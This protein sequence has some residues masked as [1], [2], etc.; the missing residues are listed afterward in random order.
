[1]IY[2]FLIL[3]F[4]SFQMCHAAAEENLVTKTPIEI[5]KQN[6][7]K[8]NIDAYNNS[9]IEYKKGKGFFV[10]INNKPS[11]FV[12]HEIT[13]TE[14]TNLKLN[15]SVAKLNTNPNSLVAFQLNSSRNIYSSCTSYAIFDPSSFNAD[16]TEELKN[17]I[18][19]FH[20]IKDNYNPKGFVLSNNNSKLVP[21]QTVDQLIFTCIQALEVLRATQSEPIFNRTSVNAK[22]LDEISDDASTVYDDFSSDTD[23]TESIIDESEFK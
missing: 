4:M 8:I 21:T 11:A 6:R 18:C 3:I 23:S 2:L 7:A 12:E 22:D 1:M 9:S 14:E 20:F 16:T 10:H 5:I 19:F 13:A 15:F 17:C